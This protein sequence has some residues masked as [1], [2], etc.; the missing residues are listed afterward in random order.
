MIAHPAAELFP[1]LDQAGLEELAAEPKV[2]LVPLS[3]KR[4]AP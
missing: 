2:R 1:L 4:G 3:E